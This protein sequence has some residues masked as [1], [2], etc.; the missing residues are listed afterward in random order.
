MRERIR[1]LLEDVACG[2]I[3]PEEAVEKLA[4]LPFV[5]LEDALIDTHR[6]L[7]RGF[8]E[9]IYCPGKSPE[10]VLEIARAILDA[11]SPVIAS[12]VDEKLWEHIRQ[13]FP[14]AE[15]RE[16]ASIVVIGGKGMEKKGCVQVVTGGTGDIPVAEEACAVAEL[17]GANVERLYDIGIAGLHRVLSKM[18]D[19]RR[20]NV[21]VAIAG[22]EGALPSVVASLVEV[23]VIAVPTSIGYGAHFG[24]LSSLLA[25]LTSCVP[26][27]AVV[28]IDNGFGAGYIAGMINRMVVEKNEGGVL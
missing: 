13:E 11:G 23:P 18:G 5:Q 10:Q 17:M 25:M 28:N 21:I 7:R 8:P 15:Y 6:E 27:V 22:M 3:G 1:K 4:R 12:R 26:G 16:K 24:G 20:A 14:D 19:L 2:K 9:V